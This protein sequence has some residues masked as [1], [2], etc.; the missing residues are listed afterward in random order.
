MEPIDM[1]CFTSPL[2]VP[3]DKHEC[4]LQSASGVVNNVIDISTDSDDEYYSIN[5]S[6]QNTFSGLDLPASTSGHQST[7]LTTNV[8]AEGSVQRQPGNA[9]TQLVRS[10]AG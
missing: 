6:E 4:Q 3:L 10:S 7:V 5:N 1:L 9:S 2:R 8:P